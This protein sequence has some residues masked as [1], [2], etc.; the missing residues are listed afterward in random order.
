MSDLTETTQSPS[1]SIKLKKFMKRHPLFSFF[2]MAYAFSWVVLI[3]FILSEWSILPKT[4][5][6]SIFFILNPFAG[7]TLAAYIMNRISGEKD[8]LRNMR[9][10]L[11]QVRA[12]WQWYIFI[13]LGIPA[14]VFLGVISLPGA[15]SSFNGLPSSFFVSYPIY[16]ILIF[17]GGGPLGEEIGWRGYALPIMQCRYG[18]LK[19]TLLLG[20]LWTF[21]HLPHFLTSAQRGGPGTGLSIFYINLPIFFLMVMAITV[22]FTWVFN[23]TQGSL[24]IV[25]L[26]HAS[27]NT[28]GS[29]M[30]PRFSASIVTSTDFAFIIGFCILAILILIFT[31]GKLGYTL[32]R[33]QSAI[34]TVSK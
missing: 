19:A 12:G 10:R 14:I 29:L 27:I 11:S 23:H 26:L 25:V 31:H 21:W 33:D 13:L 15:L 30:Q 18:A 24:F 3:P 9:R 34:T 17:F 22:I 1:E 4:K 8:V 16:F 7:P 20:V 6:Y 5:A 32:S 2:F 28:F